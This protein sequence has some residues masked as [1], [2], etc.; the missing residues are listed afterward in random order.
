MRTKHTKKEKIIYNINKPY[1]YRRAHR[2]LC[3]CR[4]EMTKIRWFTDG[5][6]AFNLS[7]IKLKG[8]GKLEE[9]TDSNVVGSFDSGLVHFGEAP[10]V[11]TVLPGKG[12]E[13]KPVTLSETSIVRDHGVQSSIK[14]LEPVEFKLTRGRFSGG[15]SYYNSL[16]LTWA[17][18]G[19]SLI[20][21]AD[22]WSPLSIWREDDLLAVVMPMRIELTKEEM[23]NE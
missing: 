1:F 20:E 19:L 22:E 4:S 11:D 5:C 12:D 10:R 23:K 7:R 6:S 17:M 21:V 9:L 14:V 13:R 16:Y 8:W 18:D 2:R 3:I 15:V